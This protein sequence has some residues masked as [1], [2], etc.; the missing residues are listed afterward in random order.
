MEPKEFKSLVEKALKA[1]ELSKLGVFWYMQSDEVIVTLD[2][3]RS[4]YSKL[5]YLNINVF[6]ANVPE[7]PLVLNKQLY[8]KGGYTQFTSRRSG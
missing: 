5:F 1:R 6:F 3:Q 2:L 7:E 4:Y 8:N